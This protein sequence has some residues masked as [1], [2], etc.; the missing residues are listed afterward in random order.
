MKLIEKSSTLRDLRESMV[1]LD[2]MKDD[3][4][5]KERNKLDEYERVIRVIR[6]AVANYSLHSF[7]LNQVHADMITSVKKLYE[8]STDDVQKT[9][10]GTF[11]DNIHSAGD[12][13]DKSKETLTRMITRLEDLLFMHNGLVDKL[14]ARDK[15]HALKIHYEEKLQPLKSSKKTEKVDRNKEKYQNALDEF[16]NIDESALRDCRDALS[17]KYTEL[18]HIL[19]LY[20]KFFIN[21]HGVS[22]SRFTK[23]SDVADRLVLER[24]TKL[25]AK[26][27]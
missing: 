8:D 3:P 19:G 22:G 25:I 2:K 15:A 13:F 4:F 10:I 23:M 16:N 5:G 24:Q 20:M 6:L 17:N 1:G 12:D 7:E 14:K 11:M 9:N 18:D 21:Y 26:S 27:S